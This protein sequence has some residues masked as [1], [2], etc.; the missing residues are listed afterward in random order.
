MKFA[1][2]YVWGTAYESKPVALILGGA[3]HRAAEAFYN[4]F[5]STGNK[6]PSDQV[7]S[8]FEYAFDQ[9]INDSDVEITL[10]KSETIESVREQGIELIKLFHSEVNP[11]EI[12]AIELP[13]SVAIPD[14]I[15]GQGNLPVRLVGI[16]D[17]VERDHQNT[18]LIVELK[19]SAQRYSSLRL[20][21]D[22]QATLYS[23]AIHKL[24]LATT[25]NS[26]LVRYDVLVKTRKPVLERYFVTRTDGDYD[27]LIHLINH[28]LKAMENRIFY[29]QTGWQCGDCSFRRSC[30]SS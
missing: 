30:F 28:V 5:K 13:F 15:N 26:C 27:H 6:M 23:Y 3:V 7:I 29:R 22:L 1:H 2:N 18:Y 16:F 9:G 25:Q 19:T 12:A 8:I 24:K 4:G 14:I 20:Q 17:L 21:Y 11:Q 10:K